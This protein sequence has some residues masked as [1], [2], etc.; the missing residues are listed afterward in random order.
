MKLKLPNVLNY[1]QYCLGGVHLIAY[2]QW[3]LVTN[4]CT[5][6]FSCSKM[7][8]IDTSIKPNT[9]VNSRITDQQSLG[10]APNV[11]EPQT[12]GESTSPILFKGQDIYFLWKAV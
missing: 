8:I 5:C 1:S 3:S 2:S 7:L 6:T 12:N 4:Q 9:S 10:I 11:G